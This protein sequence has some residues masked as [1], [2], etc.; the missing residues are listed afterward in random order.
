MGFLELLT[1]IFVVC[2]LVGVI[3]WSWWLV[4]LPEIIAFALYITWFVIVVFFAN[5]TRKDI[6][7]FE[8]KFPKF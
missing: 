6:K 3:E 4:L 8:S 5:K 1:L 7:R 2:K